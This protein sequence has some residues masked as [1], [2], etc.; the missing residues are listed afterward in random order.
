[1]STE[2]DKVATEPRKGSTEPDKINAQSRKNPAK[3][4]K[5]AAEPDKV[6]A[7][8]G[9]FHSSVLST[10]AQHVMCGTLHDKEPV[11]LGEVRWIM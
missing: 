7:K 3:L 1:M 5:V 4:D 2:P 11:I 8:P 10:A 9:I 6:A